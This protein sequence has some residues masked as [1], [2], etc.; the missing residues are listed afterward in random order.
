MFTFLPITSCQIEGE[1]VEAVTDFLFS[2]SKITADCDCS[3]DIRR[4]LFLGR[5]VMKNLDSVLKSRN[6]T[7]PTK[8]CIVKVF[9]VVTYSC[10]SCTIKKTEC[11][12]IYAFKLWC[13]RRL[14]KVWWTAKK[15]NQSIL[16]EI[17]VEY[18]LEGLMLKLQYFGYLK[19]TN[20]WESPWCWGKMKTSGEKAS[21]N[22]MAG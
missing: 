18:S 2:G 9:P 12:R 13:W 22:E 17:N 10:E 5:K 11:Q 21:E 15:S 19:Q 14:L 20:Y 7:L 8:V 6:I 16:K 1:M 3:H 4:W